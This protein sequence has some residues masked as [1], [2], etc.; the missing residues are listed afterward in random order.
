[1]PR[2][3]YALEKGGPKRLEISWKGNWKELTVRLEGKVIGSIDS[4]EQLK[5]GQ[6]FSLE[7]GSCLKVWLESKSMFSFPKVSKNDHLLH[8]SGLEPS[9]RLSNTYKLIFIFA[10]VNLAAGFSLLSHAGLPNLP[11]MGL[12]SFVVGGIFLALALLVMRKSAVALTIAIGILALDAVLV[13]I[14]P[15]ELPRFV[16]LAAV[17]FR[18][19]ILLAMLQGFGAIKALRQ[20]QPH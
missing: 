14:F 11:F 16:L 15:P 10:G 17:I 20:N 9:Q 8:P 19:L 6:E 3:K 5:T 4:P 12:Q 1:M 18:I 2:I 13:V 7:D